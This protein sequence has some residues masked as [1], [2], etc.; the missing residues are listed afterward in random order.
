MPHLN[1]RK[2]SQHRAGLYLIGYQLAAMI[3]KRLL[4]SAV[5]HKQGVGQDRSQGERQSHRPHRQQRHPQSFHRSLQM[6]TILHLQLS[7]S[8]T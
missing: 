3:H 6:L 1:G 4:G 5:Q 8:E 7:C 2:P